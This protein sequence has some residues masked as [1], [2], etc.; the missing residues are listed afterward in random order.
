MESKVQPMVKIEKIFPG[1]AASTCEVLK[2]TLDASDPKWFNNN[3]NRHILIPQWCFLISSGWIWVGVCG[4]NLPAR[5]HPPACCGH[6]PKSLQ[7][8]GQR[9]HGVQGQS[10]QGPASRRGLIVCDPNTS[11]DKLTLLWGQLCNHSARKHMC[12]HWKHIEKWLQG[13]FAEKLQV[14]PG[15]RNW[16]C[17]VSTWS[18]AGGRLELPGHLNVNANAVKLEI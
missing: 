14:R 7:Q 1:G 2:V 15:G 12:R 8:Q 9:P 3:T 16:L 11:P 13:A 5:S 18:P 4:W 10:P 17:A 6:H